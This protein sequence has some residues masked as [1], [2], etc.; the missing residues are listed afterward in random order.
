MKI[1]V[2]SHERIFLT[3][4]AHCLIGILGV[5]S[6]V[7]LAQTEQPIAY[8]GHG[9]FFDSK[10]NEIKMTLPFVEKAQAWYRAD[11]LSYMD[12]SKKREF[13]QFEKRLYAGVE[14][15]GQTRS[16]VQQRALEWLFFNSPKHQEDDRTLGKVRALGYALKWHLPERE[17]LN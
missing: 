6:P 3:F 10:G 1:R 5:L 4:A 14:L 17:G 9:A 2:Y 16:V 11:F 12:A 8:V 13:A 15:K 7:A